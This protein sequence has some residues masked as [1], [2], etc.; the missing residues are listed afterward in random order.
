MHEDNFWIPLFHVAHFC[1]E[2]DSTFAYKP[3]NLS[4]LRVHPAPDPLKVPIFCTLL[5]IITSPLYASLTLLKT[6]RFTLKRVEIG[7]LTLARI[8]ICHLLAN[9]H[10]YCTGRVP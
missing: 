9:V 4:R 5:L 6:D 10:G 3:V 2:L 7:C 1:I 8:E